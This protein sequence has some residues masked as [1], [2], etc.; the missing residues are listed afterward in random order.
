MDSHLKQAIL[1]DDLELFK[2]CI[3]EEE[4]PYPRL[5]GDSLFHFAV[6]KRAL[7][8]VTW[9]IESPDFYVDIDELGY[10][11]YPAIYYACINDNTKM[12]IL[13]LENGAKIINNYPYCNIIQRLLSDKGDAASLK[14]LLNRIQREAKIPNN[15]EN[16][17]LQAIVFAQ[18]IQKIKCNHHKVIAYDSLVSPI[19][20]YNDC[21]RRKKSLLSLN[22]VDWLNEL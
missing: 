18:L 21:K 14:Y 1:N 12:F 6:R 9:M 13:L 20:F 22:H 5:Y 4:P 19:S 7:E 8:I 3:K 15:G 2:S 10:Q 11:N 17:K 16:E